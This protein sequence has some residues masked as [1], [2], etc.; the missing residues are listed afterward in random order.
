VSG[1]G[2][3]S[4]GPLLLLSL[5]TLSCGGGRHLQSV[6][7]QPSVATA[8]NGKAQFTA[9]GGFS[10]PPSPVTL[11]SKDVA[12]CTGES[13]STPNA[14]PNGCVGFV[15]PFA[16]VDQN[17]LATCNPKTHGSGFILAGAQPIPSMIP[18]EGSQFKV[19]GYATLT[20]P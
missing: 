8:Q 10:A 4:L 2:S 9:T 6:T 5:V 1:F 14:S 18:D 7:V 15:I 16:T 3:R 17:G 13:T 20:C 12:W 11:T 19:F